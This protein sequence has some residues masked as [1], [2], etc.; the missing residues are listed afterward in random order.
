MTYNE[1][2]DYL[3]YSLD[4]QMSVLLSYMCKEYDKSHNLQTNKVLI[5]SALFNNPYHLVFSFPYAIVPRA[6]NK[7]T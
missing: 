7:T 1:Y 5:S 2:L 6:T 4:F 3:I